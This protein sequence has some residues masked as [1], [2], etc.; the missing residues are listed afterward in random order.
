MSKNSLRNDFLYAGSTE[1][2]SFFKGK[3][4]SLKYEMYPY[5]VFRKYIAGPG[6]LT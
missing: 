3:I 5:L 1:P 2:L 4:K 6:Y